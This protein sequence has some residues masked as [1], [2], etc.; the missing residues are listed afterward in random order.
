MDIEGAVLYD[1][2]FYVL[3]ETKLAVY[4][5]SVCTIGLIYCFICLKTEG[6]QYA[7]AFAAMGIDNSVSADKFC[8]NFKVVVNRLTE[9]DMEFDM[10]G[11]DAS[12]ANAFRRIL[13]AEVCSCCH[14]YHRGSC[15]L[16][17]KFLIRH[18]FGVPFHYTYLV[19]LNLQVPTM[20]IE[21][22]LMAD[23]TSVIADEVLSHRLG[24]IP[25]DADPRLFEY[26]SGL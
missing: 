16:Y 10:I 2:L 18:I 17:S 24:L 8:K 7:G 6:F 12:M 23:N 1:L 25:L 11:I 4:Y 14:L 21:K 13:I 3:Y 9:D 22:V 19:I 26:I 5:F 20:A 15:L